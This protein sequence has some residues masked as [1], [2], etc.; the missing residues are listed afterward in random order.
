MR[1]NVKKQIEDFIEL[2]VQAHSNI[3]R[4]IDSGDFPAAMQL[5][6]ECQNGAISIGTLIEEQ[7]GEGAPTVGILE[8]YCELLYQIYA[9]LEPLTGEHVFRMEHVPAELA[10]QW[11][12]VLEDSIK[13]LRYSLQHDIR[14]KKEVVFL[15]YN[16]SMW[17]SLESV[18][19]A[20][21]DDEDCDAYVIPI[22]YYD[23]GAD[24][25]FQEMHYEAD[26]F[27]KDIP[28]TQYDAY[29]FEQRHP[30]MI[31]IHNP[32]DGSNYVTSVHPFF[33]SKNLKQYTDCL[34]YI[35]YFV[36][37]EISPGDKSAVR[38]MEN[39]VTVPA[40]VHADT[41]IVQ[42]EAMRQVYI[43][44]MSE[45]AGENT[46]F[47]WEKKIL[48][49]GSPKFDRVSRIRTEAIKIPSDWQHIFIKPDGRRKKVV[50]Y[51][52]SVVAMLT[53]KQKMVDKIKRVLE[54]FRQNQDE[55]AL[56]WRPH[57]LMLATLQAM[58]PELKEEYSN[59]VKRYREEQWG[60]Y[61]D[62]PDLDRA[63]GLCDAYYGDPSSVVQ[64][65]RMAGI[66]VMIQNS[67]I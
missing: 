18:Y 38:G 46:R 3:M 55:V 13:R 4:E 43:D 6:M 15:P 31:F 39:F 20:A 2:L 50:F 11:S 33:Y 22:P 47:L 45:Y 30:D 23:K 29:D 32:Y 59:I 61:D 48:G 17:D 53:H 36:L 65:C 44:V 62:T 40:V 64:L 28:I 54:V 58:R 10:K 57:P 12:L 1:K 9:A 25:S 14:V 34:V 24:G 52:T 19:L 49:L 5:L 37:D 60:I 35:P 21:R 51:N 8:E 67:E 56:I 27:P 16:A 66:P 41:V 42:S 26:K 7:E 63:M